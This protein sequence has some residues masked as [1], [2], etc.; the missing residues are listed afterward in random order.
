MSV[1][2]LRNPGAVDGNRCVLKFLAAVLRLA[3]EPALLVTAVLTD[4]EQ[5][6]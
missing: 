1:T 6:R 5:R 2:R 4:A 3:L